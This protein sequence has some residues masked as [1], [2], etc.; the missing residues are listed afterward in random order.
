MKTRNFILLMAVLMVTVSS[1][2]QVSVNVNVGTPPVWAPAAPVEVRYYYIPDI[3]VYYDVPAS[4]YI[5]LRNGKWH[6]SA[7]LPAH[8]RG[9]DL[10]GGRTIYLTDYR[11]NAPYTLYKTHK[12][13]YK[14]NGHWKNKGHYK[15]SP[16]KA[17]FKAQGHPGKGN[18]K[19]GHGKGKR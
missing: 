11:G 4:R 18:G 12:V 3:E 9:Y 13:K 16:G 10:R 19:G 7:A 14:G 15:S 17:K 6:R 8:Y 5:Y 2:A 1:Q